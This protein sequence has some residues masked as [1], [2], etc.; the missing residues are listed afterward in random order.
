LRSSR[1]AV[2]IPVANL[3]P[4]FG[5]WEYRTN[6]IRFALLLATMLLAGVGCD[7]SEK[8]GKTISPS[9]HPVTDRKIPRE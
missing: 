6:R 4:T 7:F 1:Q 3:C 8:G 9:I 2:N 5:Y